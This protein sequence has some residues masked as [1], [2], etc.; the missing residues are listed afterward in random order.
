MHLFHEKY[1]LPLFKFSDVFYV[2]WTKK[3]NCFAQ[4]HTNSGKYKQFLVSRLTVS[5][6]TWLRPRTLYVCF[7]V[8]FKLVNGCNSSLL[9][10]VH[11]VHYLMHESSKIVFFKCKLN[12]R[13]QKLLTVFQCFLSAIVCH[14][15]SRLWTEGFARWVLDWNNVSA[16]S[17]SR[18]LLHV[19][20]DFRSWPLFPV[21]FSYF[22][23]KC[24]F[25]HFSRCRFGIGFAVGVNFCHF[26]L[27]VFQRSGNVQFNLPTYVVWSNDKTTKF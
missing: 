3:L 17:R 22:D 6:P 11:S 5:E 16:R 4:R 8:M 18:S 20:E 24:S 23:T 15:F 27:A 25:K 19:R 13:D 14:Q 10:A 1:I 7:Y 21:P 9:T 12:S 2:L 26:T